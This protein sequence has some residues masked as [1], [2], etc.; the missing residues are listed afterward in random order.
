MSRRLLALATAGLA[1]TSLAAC[2]KDDD[3]S[4]K[5]GDVTLTRAQVEA[6]AGKDAPDG[7]GK[8]ECVEGTEDRTF[9]CQ[10]TTPDGI[11]SKYLVRVSEDGVR[12][13]F[14]QQ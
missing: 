4:G 1:A 11:G 3:D 14:D 8:A 7:A 6:R 13:Q 2:G 9:T 10:V 12:L 5:A